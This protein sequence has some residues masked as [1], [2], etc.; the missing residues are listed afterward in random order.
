M[1]KLANSK[2]LSVPKAQGGIIMVTNACNVGGGG[3]L[4]RLQAVEKGE[5]DLA[6][7]KWGTQGLNRDGTLKD[8]YTKDK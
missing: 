7:S 6:I 2:C 1:D 8:G 4:F 5:F 3:T